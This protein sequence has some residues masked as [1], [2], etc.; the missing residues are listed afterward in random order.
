MSTFYPPPYPNLASHSRLDAFHA[1]RINPLPFLPDLTNQGCKLESW[2]DVF[3]DVEAGAGTV[4]GQ[5]DVLVTDSEESD[6]ESFK[7]RMKATF[8]LSMFYRRFDRGAISEAAG[9]FVAGE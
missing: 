1:P 3:P 9:I 7:V 4:A 8:I 2:E 6:D 5:E